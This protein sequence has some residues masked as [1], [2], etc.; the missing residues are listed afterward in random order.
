M[1]LGLGLRLGLR[2]YTHWGQGEVFSA[3]R[4]KSPATLTRN[5]REV[6]GDDESV[7]ERR[8]LKDTFMDIRRLR[9]YC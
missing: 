3:P 2:P 7:A 5:E 8:Q 4:T 6:T 1:R 9:V